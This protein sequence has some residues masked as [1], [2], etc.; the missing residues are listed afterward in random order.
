MDPPNM[1]IYNDSKHNMHLPDLNAN[2]QL[3]KFKRD[4]QEEVD[5]IMQNDITFDTIEKYI[6]KF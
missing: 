2:N 3:D 4:I 1:D 6:F 5:K